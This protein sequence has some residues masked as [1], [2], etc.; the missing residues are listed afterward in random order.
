MTHVRPPTCAQSTNVALAQK[1]LPG[2]DPTLLDKGS[3]RHLVSGGGVIWGYRVQGAGVSTN[4][5]DGGSSAYQ[6]E[7]VS[8][9]A[10]FQPIRA[11]VARVMTNQTRSPA[12]NS[13]YRWRYNML[14]LHIPLTC[15]NM[16]ILHIA[17]KWVIMLA[18]HC[19]EVRHHA[20][21][22]HLIPRSICHTRWQFDLLIDWLMWLAIEAT[23]GDQ[24]RYL[25]T[26]H[27][28]A[29]SGASG[30]VTRWRHN[31]L[32]QDIPKT[33]IAN[34][35]G[36]GVTNYLHRARP[37]RGQGGCDFT[38]MVTWRPAAEPTLTCKGYESVTCCRISQLTVAGYPEK[39]GFKLGILL[40]T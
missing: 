35:L 27:L 30:D 24:T 40:L 6:S 39:C 37:I 10:E 31:L 38:W 18:A 15:V 34:C 1:R 9:Y 2:T 16:L 5:S 4:Q 32:L 25:M 13:R 29:D 20:G 17:L 12:Y 33:A 8:R 36:G 26:G 23:P 22:E 3:K 21:S 28:V 14:T 11:K 7:P 19:I